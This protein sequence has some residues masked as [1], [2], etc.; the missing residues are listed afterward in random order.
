VAELVTPDHVGH[1]GYVLLAVGMWSLASG[2][3]RLGWPFRFAGELVW[4]GIG[5]WLGM[6]SIWA[7]GLLFL[8]ID[9]K[10]AWHAFRN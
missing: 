7:W 2:R 4:V 5:F 6:S 9:L 3:A 1:V 8:C 10:G